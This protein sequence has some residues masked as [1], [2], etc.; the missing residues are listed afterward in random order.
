MI[1][2]GLVITAALAEAIKGVTPAG[3]DAI[4]GAAFR[5]CYNLEGPT[6]IKGDPFGSANGIVAAIVDAA[7]TADERLNIKREKDRERKEK[8]KDL[9][10][11]RGRTRK[12]AEERGRTRKDAEERGKTRTDAE[13]HQ[14]DRKIDRLTEGETLSRGAREAL[15]PSILDSVDPFAAAPCPV[16]QLVTIAAGPTM[17]SPIPEGYVRWWYDQQGDAGWLTADGQKVR[18]LAQARRLLA[19][20]WRHEKKF[21]GAWSESSAAVKST[22]VAV[23]GSAALEAME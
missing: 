20:W 1:T 12:N 21:P 10:K 16:D 11:E 8:W 5:R 14:T 15:P 19:T 18:T 2:N 23:T 13:S 9:T 6:E 17:A 4:L 3:Q 22:G 7:R